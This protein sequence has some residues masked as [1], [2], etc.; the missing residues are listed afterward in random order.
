M[1]GERLVDQLASSLKTLDDD[2]KKKFKQSLKKRI[3]YLIKQA[4]ED[5]KQVSKEND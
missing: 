3:P 5:A 4:T 1:A 2:Q